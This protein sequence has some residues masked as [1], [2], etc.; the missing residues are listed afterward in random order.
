MNVNAVFEGGG[1]KAIGLVGAVKAAEQRGITFGQ[2]AGTSSGAIVA[3]LLAAGYRADELKE[4]LFETSFQD[5]LK[6]DFFHYFSG[7]GLGTRMFLK[8]GL[9]SNASL[10][11]WIADL[12][13][14]KGVV[15][16]GDLPKN[17]V[18]IIASDISNGRMMVLPDD[19][20]EYGYNPDAFPIAKAIAMSTSIPYF[21]EPVKLGKNYIVDG[22][23]LSN[24]PLWLFDQHY[25]KMKSL[26]RRLDSISLE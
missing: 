20:I 19:L 10:E 11:K 21:F 3:T 5:F 26:P 2:V 16:F 14:Y 17:Q 7:V 23:L 6:K 12:L 24:Y 13:K 4:I 1:A 8:K 9:Y 25:K 18:R 22:A 15:C